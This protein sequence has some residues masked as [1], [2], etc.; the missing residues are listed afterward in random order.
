MEY[1]FAQFCLDDSGDLSN[2]IDNLLDGSEEGSDG[3]DSACE[4]SRL[5]GKRR[6]SP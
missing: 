1:Q 2:A 3:E 4:N 5:I 6:E